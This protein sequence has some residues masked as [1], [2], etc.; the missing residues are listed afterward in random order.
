MLSFSAAPGQFGPEVREPGLRCWRVE[1]MKAVPLKSSEV[2]AFFNGD[3]YLVLHNKGDQ[4]ADLHMWLGE[5]YENMR[6]TL[7][8]T[9]ARGWT[10]RAISSSGLSLPSNA[11][12]CLILGEPDECIGSTASSCLPF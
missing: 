2:G 4:G 11:A 1:K 5:V 6:V 8:R 10:I 9:A 12:H 7:S 3:S